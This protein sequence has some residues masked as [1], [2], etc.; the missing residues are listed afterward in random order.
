MVMATILPLTL[1]SSWVVARILP[2]TRFS[3]RAVALKLPL[4][5]NY[6]I[7]TRAWFP[8]YTH[9]FCI[10]CVFTLGISLWGLVPFKGLRSHHFGTRPKLQRPLWQS[11]EKG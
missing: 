10:Y 2:L 11:V 3:S 7:F 6:W 1:F 8:S 9:F 4:F 5:T